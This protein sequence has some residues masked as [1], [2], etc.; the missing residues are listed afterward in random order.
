MNDASVYLAGPITGLRY[1]EAT[2]WR[3]YAETFLASWGIE[4]LSPM[5]GK[6][7][8]EAV[9]VIEA[10]SYG[11]DKAEWALSS[12]PG[13]TMRDHGD[14]M[15][16]DV[17]LANFVGCGDR[18]SIGTVLE[19]AWAHAYRK[20]LIVAMEPGNVHDHAMIRQLAGYVVPS[21]DA[22]LNIIP[23]I[24]NAKRVGEPV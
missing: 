24:L 23:A 12:A 22:A 5:R 14:C 1:G 13:F 15:A 21:L 18:V 8:L 11:E 10:V 2:D 7:Y 17:I 4:G 16:A 19:V 3:D 6:Q 20:Q 9:G